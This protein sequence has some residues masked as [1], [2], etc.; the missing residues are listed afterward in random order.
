MAMEFNNKRRNRLGWFL[1]MG[2]VFNQCC[3]PNFPQIVDKK[4]GYLTSLREKEGKE[5]STGKVDTD[6][7]CGG[8]FFRNFQEPV[9]G[10]ADP[11]TAKINFLS[12]R[13][14][15]RFEKP[16]AMGIGKVWISNRF[17][18]ADFQQY[19]EKGRGLDY[20]AMAKDENNTY[21]KL[22]EIDQNDGLIS[23][24]TDNLTGKFYGFTGEKCKSLTTNEQV[25]KNYWL[26][27]AMNYRMER[28][29]KNE[30]G[31]GPEH[32]FVALR[33]ISGKYPNSTDIFTD[34]EMNLIRMVKGEAEN[35]VVRELT[36]Y[37][38]D[39]TFRTAENICPFRWEAIQ[40]LTVDSLNLRKVI[41]AQEVGQF[42]PVLV[43][44]N[45][46][47]TGWIFAGS[48]SKNHKAWINQRIPRRVDKLEKT[49]ILTRTLRQAKTPL[50]DS[51]TVDLPTFLRQFPPAYPD[52]PR[53]GK[54]TIV[55]IL[56]PGDRYGIMELHWASGLNKEREVLWLKVKKLRT[57]K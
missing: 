35:V 2:L 33:K 31:P 8:V 27:E 44:S 43:S 11:I 20:E 50:I 28:V 26:S 51:L 1:V 17:T 41:S 12:S 13:L 57:K 6:L 3:P 55:N 49:Q 23:I 37:E 9:A 42:N 40:G 45:R 22:Y 47:D 19:Y 32:H 16:N 34:K 21:L 36:E 39:V 46:Q 48:A 10:V 25:T 14:F 54:G 56:L 53:S 18:D 15:Y 7:L 52:A 5:L 29:N 38:R 24:Y 4:L 30:E